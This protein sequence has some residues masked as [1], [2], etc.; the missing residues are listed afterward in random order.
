MH[1]AVIL[2]SLNSFGRNE[3]DS[4]IFQGIWKPRR[5]PNP[6]FFEDLDPYKMTPIV[7]KYTGIKIWESFNY[8]I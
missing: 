8:N 2:I 3:K 1:L 7:R 4:F 5:I 6:N